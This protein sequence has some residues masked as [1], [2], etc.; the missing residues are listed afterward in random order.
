MEKYLQVS[1]FVFNCKVCP[2]PC[3]GVSKMSYLFE[4]DASF[5]ERYEQKLI[6]HINTSTIFK[7]NKTTFK[8]YPDVEVIDKNGF[9]FYIE[10]KV[11]QR[12]FMSVKN[13]SRQ[14]FK[15]IRNSGT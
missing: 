3:D 4:R 5:S 12:T 8:G 14:Q 10:V 15:T 2:T 11:Q 13:Y 1:P 7:A 6:D 9:K